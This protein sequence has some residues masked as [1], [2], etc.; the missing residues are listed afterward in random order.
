MKDK[1]S[2]KHGIIK[3]ENGSKRFFEWQQE[4]HRIALN[5][6][7]HLCVNLFICENL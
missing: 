7:S 3:E 6:E 1:N 4:Y 5:K 2:Q